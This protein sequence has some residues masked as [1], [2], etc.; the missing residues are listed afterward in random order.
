MSG[1]TGN[2][3][4]IVAK[5]S[6]QYNII[7]SNITRNDDH[8][9]GTAILISRAHNYNKH[10]VTSMYGLYLEKNVHNNVHIYHT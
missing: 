5:L 4:D 7:T 9:R 8:E 6:F 2:S 3:K 10:A 1:S